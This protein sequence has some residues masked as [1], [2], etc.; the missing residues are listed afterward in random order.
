MDSIHY[1]AIQESTNA[2]DSAPF[3]RF[4]SGCIRD[5]VTR[6]VVRTPQKMPDAILALLRRQQDLNIHQIAAKLGK[7]DSAVKRAI[8]QLRESGRLRRMG[9]DKGG[10]WEVV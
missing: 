5:A 6:G 10:R 1:Q 3:I 7:S 9:P 4:M 8:R 2:T